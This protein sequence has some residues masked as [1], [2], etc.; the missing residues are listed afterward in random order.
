MDT[1]NQDATK[2]ELCISQNETNKE[3][4]R[5]NEK[6]LFYYMAKIGVFCIKQKAESDK[7][8]LTKLL[9]V[10]VSLFIWASSGVT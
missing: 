9:L 1:W 8:W 7:L 2:S 4:P 10:I 6:W 3:E 5:N